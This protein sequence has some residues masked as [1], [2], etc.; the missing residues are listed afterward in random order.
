MALA[1]STCEILK[2]CK[3]LIQE[4]RE[5]I[6]QS[7]YEILF[8]KHPSLQGMFNMSHFRKDGEKPGRQVQCLMKLIFWHSKCIAKSCD[9]LKVLKQLF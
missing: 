1:E 3:P 2:V 4:N 9:L 6:G 8:E 7:F 5:A